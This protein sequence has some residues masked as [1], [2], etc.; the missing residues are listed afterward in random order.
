MDGRTQARCGK[1]TTR[2]WMQRV[3][4]SKQG[5][6]TDQRGSLMRRDDAHGSKR[7]KSEEREVATKE[8]ESEKYRQTEKVISDFSVTMET[9]LEEFCDRQKWARLAE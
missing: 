4:S 5:S 2:R 1:A 3:V 9:L 7:Q 6:E 8:R